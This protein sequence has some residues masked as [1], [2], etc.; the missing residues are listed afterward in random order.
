MLGSRYDDSSNDN[1]D[2]TNHPS[3]SG[4][5]SILKMAGATIPCR[6]RFIGEA[7]VSGTLHSIMMGLVCGTTSAV[8]FPITVGPIV[9]YLLGSIGGYSFGLYQHWNQSKTYALFCA[10]KYPTLLSHAIFVEQCL[11][12][13]SSIQQHPSSSDNDN[14]GYIVTYDEND[15][16][17][18]NITAINTN[19]TIATTTNTNNTAGSLEDWIKEGGL[20]RLTWSILASQ[21][22]RNAVETIQRKERQQIIDRILN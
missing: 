11:V 17:N 16:V 9:P 18:N 3:G 5:P 8:C 14:S 15:Y 7:V 12:V 22:C 20:G 6:A 19:T 10:R 2:G 21:R 4:F 13:P 1:V